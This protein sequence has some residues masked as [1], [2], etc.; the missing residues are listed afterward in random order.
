[1]SLTLTLA[2]A[3]AYFGPASH[4]RYEV[5][6]KFNE[7]Q[8]TAALVH[9]TRRISREISQ[10]VEDETINNT[11]FYRPDYAVFEQALHMLVSGEAIPNREQTGP[12]FYAQTGMTA[13]F[14]SDGVRQQGGDVAG[15][16]EISPEAATW[17]LRP[18]R[19]IYLARG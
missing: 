8:K 14:N 10:P 6:K 11:T 9:A 7:P 13:R 3:E 18:R 16:N 15:I 17:L 4:V 12:A 5:W 2:A 1:M 19:Q